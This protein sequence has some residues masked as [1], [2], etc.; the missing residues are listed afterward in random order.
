MRRTRNFPIGHCGVMPSCLMIL[1][2]LS[3]SARVNVTSSSGLDL[4]VS[5]AMSAIHFFTSVSMSETYALKYWW[6]SPPRTGIASGRPTL[7]TARGIGASLCGDRQWVLGRAVTPS[8][9]SWR[10]E[11]CKIRNPYN[12]RNEI[13]GSAVEMSYRQEPDRPTAICRYRSSRTGPHQR[14]QHRRDAS[15]QAVTRKVP[16]RPVPQCCEAGV[17]DLRLHCRDPPPGRASS[18]T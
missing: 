9:R 14:L 1:P 6:C 13:V 11:C 8:H 2:H 15:P 17:N 12:S 10:W 4:A 7:W 5:T 16:A 18:H 3:A